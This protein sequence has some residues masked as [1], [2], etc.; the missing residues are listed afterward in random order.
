[1]HR[2]RAAMIPTAD[3]KFGAPGATHLTQAQREHFQL[4]EM[5][6]QNQAS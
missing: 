5:P 3:T 4:F 1:M 6:I 2:S